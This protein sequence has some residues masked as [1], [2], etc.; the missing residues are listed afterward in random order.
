MVI[1]GEV[2]AVLRTLEEAGHA[3]Y[4]VGGCVRDL[5][6][7]RVPQDYDM[8]TSARP[9]ELLTLFPKAIPTGL[10]H[11]TVTVVTDEGRYEVTTFRTDG[12]YADHRHPRAVTFTDSIIEDLSRRDF[13]ANAMAMD[14]KGNILDPFGGQQDISQ[15]LLRCVG[16]PEQRFSEDA[17]RIMRALRFAATLGFTI[18]SATA[19]AMENRCGDLKEIAPERLR[20]E[21]TKLLCGE[22]ACAVLERWPQV[23]GVFIPEILPCV[24]LDQRN[25]HHC[26]DVWG[27]IAHSVQA[28]PPKA[29]LRWTMLLHDIGKPNTFTVDDKGTGH[30]Y[31]HARVS[32]AMA[33]AILRRLRFD[34][35]TRERIVT[36]VDWHDRDVPRTEKGLRR[37][38]HHLGE[39]GVRQLIAVK[40]ADNDAQHPDYR[41]RA[42]EID[43]AEAILSQVLAAQDCFSLRQLAV[44]GHD[45][46]ALGLSGPAIGAMLNAL[47]DA[48]VD[49]TLPN[50]RSALLKRAG[51]QKAE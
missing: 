35:A 28:I 9:E 37:A 20:D 45:M 22:N 5:C 14:C 44:N 24:G 40:R 21:M 47:L 3:A 8:A 42:S 17:L 50:E 18:E 2:Q 36:L 48:V 12:D 25:P 27:H 23:I 15:K 26:Y 32:T 29:V 31:G 4:L 49:G 33:D 19:A 51:Q 11:G 10:Q 34:N 46:A 30:F 43:K 7:H 16:E 38:L 39:E 41:G 1:P 13:T 6:M